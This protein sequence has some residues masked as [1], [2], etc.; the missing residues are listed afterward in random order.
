MRLRL[1]VATAASLALAL[2]ACSSDV[3]DDD[4]DAK[5]AS[6]ASATPEGPWTFTDGSGEVVELDQVPTRIIAHAPA[7]AALISYGIRPVGIYGDEPVDT[8]PNLDGVDLTGI[9]I[10]GEEWGS[11][12]VAKASTLAPDLIVADWWPAEKAHSGLENSVKAKSKKLAELA[13]V[14]GPSQGG[15]ILNLAEGYEDLAETL[16]A[17]VEDSQ[18]AEDKAA[19]EE[20]R[21]AFVAAMEDKDLTALAVSPTADLLY[22]ANPEYAPELLD[23]TEW[24][25]QVVTPDTPDPDFPY[26]ENLSW[27]NADKYQ[28]DVLLI[29][30]RSFEEAKKTVAAQPTWTSIRAAEAGQLIEWPAF[31]LHT[32]ADYADALT[33]L[34]ADLADVDDTIGD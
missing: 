19:F 24:G 17:D 30:S 26:W 34:T 23:F 33:K 4:D 8:D 32:Y 13:P 10:L 20:A 15:S 6:G 29:D 7:A 5:P 28:P 22:A 21:D 27:E 12:D 14:V 25:L 1:A 3:A 31:W 18:G 11:I 2:S 16:G 9:E